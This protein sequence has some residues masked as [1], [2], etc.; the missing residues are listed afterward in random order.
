MAVVSQLCSPW[1]SR[2]GEYVL[3]NEEKVRNKALYEYSIY[4]SLAD[5]WI[6][7]ECKVDVEI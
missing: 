2:G 1:E 3:N 7:R 5:M 4:E 6:F